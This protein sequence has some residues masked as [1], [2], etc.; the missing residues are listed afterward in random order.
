MLRKN[1]KAGYHGG[2]TLEKI[3]I[4]EDDI[5]F[6]QDEILNDVINAFYERKFP[7]LDRIENVEDSRMQ[8]DGIDKKLILKNGKEIWIDEKWRRKDYGDFLLEEYSNKQKQIVGW[9]GRKK[10]TDYIV[11]IIIP[12]KKVYFLPFL[13]LQIAWKKNY[14]LWKKS[15]K[16][17]LAENEGYTTTNL[18]IPK[19]VLLEA[20][21]Q[22]MEGEF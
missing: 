6:S 18:A 8:R 16:T 22:A 2:S 17:K 14:R 19:D 21:K 15:Y 13:F 11:Y 20:L 4:F 3:N 5:G 1:E 9:L 12:S 10:K 7:H